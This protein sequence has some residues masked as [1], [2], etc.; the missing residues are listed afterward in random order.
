MARE[1]AKRVPNL[2]IYTDGVMRID[3]IGCSYPHLFEPYKGEDGESTPGFSVVGLIPK[4]PTHSQAVALVIDEINKLL[5]ANKQK[6]G[7]GFPADKKCLRDGDV[8][9]KETNENKYTLNC[10]EV[11]PPSVRDRKKRVITEDDARK[12]LDPENSMPGVYGGCRINLLFR[13]WWQS[14]KYGKRVN[15]NLLA[16]QYTAGE[17]EGHMPFGEGR[18]SEEAIEESFD[19]IDDGFEDGG[20]DGDEFEG[21]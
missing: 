7:K 3:D 10:R 16:V 5:V 12:A 11:R 21:L 8:S 13:L 20:F 18:I 15:A 1:I 17:R 14:N 4:G 9:G 19:S 6:P 2:V